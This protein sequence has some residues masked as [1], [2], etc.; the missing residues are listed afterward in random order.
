MA[1]I[2]EEHKLM[3][4]LPAIPLQTCAVVC[5]YILL[6]EFHLHMKNTGV[7]RLW[8]PSL[9]AAILDNILVTDLPCGDLTFHERKKFSIFLSIFVH[10]QLV[11]KLH[12]PGAEHCKITERR[13][14]WRWML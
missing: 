7:L 6:L 3:K 4:A 8:H 2:F 13:M 1:Y 5:N 9:L 12:G 11:D 10:Y 14:R